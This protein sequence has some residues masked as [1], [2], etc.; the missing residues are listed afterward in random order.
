M[1][2]IVGLTAAR[3][4]QRRQ[5]TPE[6]LRQLALCAL[7]SEWKDWDFDAR[8]SMVFHAHG[9]HGTQTRLAAGA[10]APAAIAAAPSRVRFL[11]L[12]IADRFRL[13][14]AARTSTGTPS[15]SS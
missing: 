6:L 2:H 3:V 1:P 15:T 13:A 11:A 10:V 12:P 8:S 14:A 9:A 4:L 5:W 7:E